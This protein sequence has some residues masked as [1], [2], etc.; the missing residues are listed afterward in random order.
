M[1]GARALVM[2]GTRFI[3]QRLVQELLAAGH[4][5]TC[6]HLGNR[7]PFGAAVRHVLL[8]RNDHAAV[9]AGLGG[10]RFDLVFEH[11][12][13][14]PVGTRAADVEAVLDAVGGAATR[15]VFTSSF[16]VYPVGAAVDESSPYATRD[17]P[18]CR[19]KV[20][21]E[22]LLL[23][24]A[25]KDGLPLAIVRPGFVFGPHNRGYQ[26]RFFWD[27][28][29]AG[30]PIILPDGGETLMQF[31]FVDDVARLLRL[32]SEH[33]A[34]VGEAFNVAYPP[35]TQRGW[36]EALAQAG[37][38]RPTFVEVPRALIFELGGT[39]FDAPHYFGETLDVAGVLGEFSARADT[40]R[41]VLG[42][43]LTPRAEAL[44]RTR[45]WCV[46][47]GQAMDGPLDFDFEDRLIAAASEA[48]G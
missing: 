28:L 1:S 26:E 41:E 37:G 21:S 11:S 31:A 17:D 13:V 12:Y 30:R 5:V 27:R 35:T 9:R 16:A 7:D 10:E 25:R 15:Y 2:G 42:F 8:D 33:P 22:R 34:A 46:G 43:Q 29:A 47:E 20:A 39:P 14:H 23:H 19:D 38:Y 4:D 40:A 6:A 45:A 24:R 32:V 18:F 36:V 48:A 3:G 44:A